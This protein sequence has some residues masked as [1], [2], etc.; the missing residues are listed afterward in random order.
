[1]HICQCDTPYNHCSAWISFSFALD[2]GQK[3][4]I[5]KV[6]E[7]CA[8][9]QPASP[10]TSPQRRTE[11]GP[12]RRPQRNGGHLLGN[13]EG[14]RKQDSLDRIDT[15]YR[16]L[17]VAAYPEHP[18]HP[19]KNSGVL[20][21]RIFHHEDREGHE[22]RRHYLRSAQISRHEPRSPAAILAAGSCLRQRPPQARREH[23]PRM[24]TDKH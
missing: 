2:N 22:G 18:V 24:N 9:S 20:L 14:R 13:Q 5:L 19:V 6:R 3:R 23:S 15:I 11:D 4:C 7:E 10:D 16:M 8:R 1:M 21:T 12:S 17:C